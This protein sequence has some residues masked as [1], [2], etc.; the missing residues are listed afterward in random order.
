MVQKWQLSKLISHTKCNVMYV[1]NTNCNV[2]M[3]LNDN[4]LP[5]IDE[6]KDLWR[7]CRLPFCPLTP[8]S[9]TLQ[10][11]LSCGPTSFTMF[12]FT[13]CS[14]F[15]A[16]FRLWLHVRPLLEYAACVWSPYR[17]GQT[18]RVEFAQR[19]FTKRLPG[20]HSLDCKV[21]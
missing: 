13:G 6:V 14:N 15:M 11:E 8:T 17:V 10:L 5:I 19:K 4:I 7:H 20:Y 2:S 16:C 3:T 9:V 1:G 21:D 18:N 12:Y